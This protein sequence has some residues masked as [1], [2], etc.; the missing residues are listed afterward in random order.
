MQLTIQ[1]ELNPLCVTA[2]GVIETATLLEPTKDTIAS[3]ESVKVVPICDCFCCCCI[4]N[5]LVI[6]EKK[7]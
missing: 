2:W 6:C 5:K 7:L 3:Y 4:S 1:L